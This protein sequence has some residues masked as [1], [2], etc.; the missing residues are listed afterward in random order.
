MLYRVYN[1]VGAML[2][3]GGMVRYGASLGVRQASRPEHARQ[4]NNCLLFALISLLP[5]TVIFPFQSCNHPRQSVIF[6]LPASNLDGGKVAIFC[7]PPRQSLK[8]QSLIQAKPYTHLYQ[9]EQSS[10]HQSLIREAQANQRFPTPIFISKMPGFIKHLPKKSFNIARG[11]NFTIC[12]SGNIIWEASKPALTY[13]HLYHQ[14]GQNS[15]CKHLH[16][17]RQLLLILQGEA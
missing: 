16:H 10:Q 4:F 8:H 13:S 11:L 9:Q 3:R 1:R 15:K 2:Y 6:S 17:Y 7:L 14:Q 12:T 5:Q